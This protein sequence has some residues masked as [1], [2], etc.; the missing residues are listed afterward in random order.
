MKLKRT[1][2][3]FS[4]AIVGIL[5]FHNACDAI[6]FGNM[7]SSGGEKAIKAQKASFQAS[8][9]FLKAAA[10]TFEMFS[11]IELNIS[12]AKPSLYELSAKGKMSLELLQA[13]L[14]EFQ[15]IKTMRRALDAASADV[16]RQR[17][18]GVIFGEAAF[19]LES[20]LQLKFIEASRKEGAAGLLDLCIKSIEHLI[21]PNRPMGKVYEDIISKSK[22]S[23]FTCPVTIT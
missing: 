17:D 10:A 4:I 20:E 3:A 21:S 23:Q 12:S 13:A 2:I 22:I 16:R 11:M 6:W 15:S 14:E 1:I 19:S 18:Y 5:G 8:S 7:G 9:K